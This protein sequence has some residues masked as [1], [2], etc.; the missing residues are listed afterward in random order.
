MTL[1]DSPKIEYTPDGK[2]PEKGTTKKIIVRVALIV[3]L[4]AALL[5]NFTVWNQYNVPAQIANA[6]GAIQGRVLLAA[7]DPLPDAEVFVANAPSVIARTDSQGNFLL[8]G[9][10]AGQQ[11]LIVG[12]NARGEEFP[13]TVLNGETTNVGPVTFATPIADDWW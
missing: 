6:D 8:Q 7:G 9:V 4:V 3:L 13:V 10:P 2:P 1:A 5:I 11:M 12:F